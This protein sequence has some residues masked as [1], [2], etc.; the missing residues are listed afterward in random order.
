MN[1]NEN[2]VYENFE[3]SGIVAYLTDVITLIGENR[4]INP[5]NFITR[6]FNNLE[7]ETNDPS[8]KAFQLL[9]MSEIGQ[10]N[11]EECL[12]SSFF[13][14]YDDESFNITKNNF[15]LLLKHFENCKPQKIYKK[16]VK[17]L[18]IQLEDYTN[19]EKFKNIT[20]KLC[21]IRITY[22]ELK[23]TYEVFKKINSKITKD[24]I[25]LIQNKL[26][27]ELNE[28]CV[29]EILMFESSLNPVS[30][31]EFA[32]DILNSFLFEP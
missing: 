13:C 24:H 3:N 26:D 5:Y 29:R 20:T 15:V 18:E 11:F 21:Q 19:F 7:L 9:Q 12:T 10:N 4:P 23:D 17:F 2:N 28:D 32:I 31:E 27:S 6:Y 1:T 25:A 8:L 16:F 14:L 30:D 22:Q